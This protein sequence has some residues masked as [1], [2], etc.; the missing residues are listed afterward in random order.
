MRMS[1]PLRSA[2]QCGRTT[3]RPLPLLAPGASVILNASIVASK[4]FA[5]WSVYSATK[6]RLLN[7][8][9][10]AL[11]VDREQIVNVLVRDFAQAGPVA[12]TGVCEQDVYFSL[13]VFDLAI[14]AV[15]VFRL[16]HVSLHCGHV[17]ADVG[18]G[19][20]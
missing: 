10:H 20:V 15:Q 5:E 18:Y 2:D 8:E 14:K 13:L 9:N 7:R 12:N 1:L 6:A 3:G 11:D 17:A 16:G 19:R 4:G